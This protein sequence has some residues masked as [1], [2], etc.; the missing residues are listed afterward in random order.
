MAKTFADVVRFLVPSNIQG[1][2]GAALLATIAQL[3]DEQI[4]RVRAG[5]NA[6][7]P[8][9]ALDDTLALVGFDR[10][11]PRGRSETSAHYAQRL[12]R[13]RAPRGHR[14][15]GGAF[16]LLEQLSEYFGGVSSWLTDTHGQRFGR[17]ASGVERH[18]NGYAWTWDSRPS[19]D[20]ARFWLVLDASAFAEAHGTD[21]PAG[22]AL[23]Q[24]GLGFDDASAIRELV[25]GVRP[26]RPSGTLAEWLVIH[27]ASPDTFDVSFDDS[28][29]GTEVHPATRWARWSYND[30][31][32][33]RAA[34][35]PALRYISLDPLRNNV[36]AGDQTNFPSA[37]EDATGGTITGDPASFPAWVLT[38]PPLRGDPASFP[39]VLR[40]LDDGD[41]NL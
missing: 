14:V 13:W 2:D 31:G 5:L 6:R 17:S 22:E 3:Q 30:A 34:R 16:A 28:F 15:R 25:H 18:E 38:G 32:T 12:L 26:W 11:I 37:F 9:R 1:G 23:G 7:F 21:A 40:L 39:A 19:S 4:T 36:Y 20:W 27:L 8:T 33:Q 41:P 29:G 10:G 35:D 24:T